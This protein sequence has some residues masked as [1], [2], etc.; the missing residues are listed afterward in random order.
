MKSEETEKPQE[1]PIIDIL[2]TVLVV[3]LLPFYYFFAI[4]LGRGESRQK[5]KR[6]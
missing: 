2:L 6:G 3:V 5:R 1:D 4:I